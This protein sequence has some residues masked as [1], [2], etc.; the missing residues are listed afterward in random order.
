MNK[1]WYS[2]MSSQKISHIRYRNAYKYLDP[3][4]LIATVFYQ[5]RSKTMMHS[6]DPNVDKECLFIVYRMHDMGAN[7]EAVNI[8]QNRIYDLGFSIRGKNLYYSHSLA[9]SHQVAPLS[10]IHLVTVLQRNVS[11]KWFLRYQVQ[12][13]EHIL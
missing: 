12:F 4:L 1:T 11:E 3:N 5:F 10:V 13:R 8:C 6:V 7:F 9:I 2:L